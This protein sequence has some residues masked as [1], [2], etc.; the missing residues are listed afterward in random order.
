MSRQL[1]S[2][3]TDDHGLFLATGHAARELARRQWPRSDEYQTAPDRQ[4]SPEEPLTAH[5]AFAILIV[6]LIAGGYI[7]TNHP[8]MG[9]GLAA[10]S[11]V[12][13]ILCC[14]DR[15]WSGFTDSCDDA[16]TRSCR[17]PGPRLGVKAS[18]SSSMPARPARPS[19]RCTAGTGYAYV[20]DTVSPASRDTGRRR[21]HREQHHVQLPHGRH[22]ATPP[23]R[24]Q[25]RSGV[26]DG[27]EHRARGKRAAGPADG[28]QGRVHRANRDRLDGPQ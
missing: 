20:D 6:L 25:S 22:A 15:L 26:G 18:V 5:I 21:P 27:R 1:A 12:P 2:S 9:V 17:L 10:L 14:L 7:L 23:R 13:L 11:W 19:P 28:I 3:N 8:V 16:G 4:S 24:A